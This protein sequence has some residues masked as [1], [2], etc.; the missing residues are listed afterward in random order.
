M[1]KANLLLVLAIMVIVI[2]FSCQQ[3]PAN[4]NKDEKKSND[5]TFTLSGT[6]STIIAGAANK[7]AYI[8]ILENSAS[9]PS[10]IK[11]NSLSTTSPYIVT[12]SIPG[13]KAGYY[14]FSVF[15]DF[16]GSQSV[17]TGDLAHSTVVPDGITLTGDKT[18]NVNTWVF[19]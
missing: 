19:Y 7:Y 15:I 14:Y 1:R 18:Y 11:T 8:V 6:L 2:F 9:S 12:Y 4:N 5:P 16:D 13:L 3:Q 17:T 10:F